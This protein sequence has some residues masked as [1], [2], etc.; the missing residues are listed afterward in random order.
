MTG[1]SSASATTS[2]NVTKPIHDV[3]LALK[4]RTSCCSAYEDPRDATGV[5][6]APSLMRC[7]PFGGSLA[8]HPR[9]DETVGEVGQQVHQ[10]DGEGVDDHHAL[11]HRIVALAEGAD[12]QLAQ[13]RS[14]E[15]DLGQHRVSD[16]DAEIESD[17]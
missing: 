9:V 3:A 4:A 13:S 6:S 11:Q 2:R 7:A 8:F 5:G 17:D 12:D 15:D 16:Q 10:D 1:A 14:V